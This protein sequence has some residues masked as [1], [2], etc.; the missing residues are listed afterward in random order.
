[1]ETSLTAQLKQGLKNGGG[2]AQLQARRLA[3][4][5][6]LALQ[7]ALVV[8]HSSSQV[9]EAFIT[10]RIA[11]DHGQTFGTLPAGANLQAILEPLVVGLRG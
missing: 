9:A 3:E 7:A 4:D 6:A 5:L 8:R 11:R 2:E 10:S 1:V